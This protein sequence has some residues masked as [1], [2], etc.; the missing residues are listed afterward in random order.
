MN[1]IKVFFVILLGFFLFAFIS[2]PMASAAEITTEQPTTTEQA[3]ATTLSAD[4]QIVINEDEIIIGE[5]TLSKDEAI[6][7]LADILEVYAGGLLQRLGIPAIIAAG[8]LVGLLIFGLKRLADYI[9]ELRQAK[10]TNAGIS[11]TNTEVKKEIQTLAETNAKAE[12]RAA[13]SEAMNAV[14]LD[15]L[16]T[17]TANSSNEGIA[18]YGAHLK[19]AA[20]NVLAMNDKVDEAALKSILKQSSQSI[21]KQIVGNVVQKAKEKKEALIEAAK[22]SKSKMY[23][24]LTDAPSQPPVQEG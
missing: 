23:A 4:I 20:E 17:M 11:S 5:F 12:A 7:F 15:A 1:K 8:V 14:I 19:T 22:V 6:A 18:A 3:V 13:K 16:V 9:K 24:A 2:A 10:E 21:G